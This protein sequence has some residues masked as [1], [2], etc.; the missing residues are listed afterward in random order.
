MLRGMSRYTATDQHM[1]SACTLTPQAHK[2][3]KHTHSL[4]FYEF[5][6]S[7]ICMV[8]MMEIPLEIIDIYI[9]TSLYIHPY[10]Y[11]LPHTQFALPLS[12]SCLHYR[13]L[14]LS[15]LVSLKTPLYFLSH[16]PPPP[17]IPP[18]PTHTQLALARPPARPHYRAPSLSCPLPR[19]FVSAPLLFPHPSLL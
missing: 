15:P 9:R 4:C 17:P 8:G 5:N 2:R 12:P 11:T 10:T 6:N 7:R 3:H 14:S 1:M 18:F 16:T 19:L 13:T